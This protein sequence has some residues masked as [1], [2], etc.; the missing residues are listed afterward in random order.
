MKT[1]I[2][3]DT[4]YYVLERHCKKDGADCVE[5]YVMSYESD[6]K[7]RHC[8]DEDRMFANRVDAEKKA[9]ELNGK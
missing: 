1:N 4:F 3:T 9:M 6:D 2:E 7:W 5:H 8:L